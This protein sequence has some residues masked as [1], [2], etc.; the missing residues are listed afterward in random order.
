MEKDG[1][2]SL[3]YL[4]GIEQLDL[5]Y[6]IFGDPEC[7]SDSLLSEVNSLISVVPP[8][9]YTGRE[10]VTVVPSMSSTISLFFC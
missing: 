9:P 7:N 4:A 8:R 3:G 1:F 2:K 5:P 10:P 6:S